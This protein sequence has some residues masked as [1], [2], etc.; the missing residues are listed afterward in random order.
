LGAVLPFHDFDQGRVASIIGDHLIGDFL[1]DVGSIVGDPSMMS[2]FE[3]ESR[4]QQ[5]PALPFRRG[6]GWGGRA[7]LASGAG[8]PPS[9]ADA[10]GRRVPRLA[11][12]T[13]A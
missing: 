4:S 3:A 6:T 5:Q 8:E 1:I 11:D 13:G 12:Y 10:A 9:A 7:N 2:S